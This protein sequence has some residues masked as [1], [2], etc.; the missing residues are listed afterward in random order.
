MKDVMKCK[1][2]IILMVLGINFLF[3]T[4]LSL[5]NEYNV[6]S[7]VFGICAMGVTNVFMDWW[8]NR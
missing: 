1:I 3:T 2:Y 6:F 4:T 8:L 5:M 7:Y